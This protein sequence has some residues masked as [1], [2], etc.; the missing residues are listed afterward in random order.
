MVSRCPRV[1]SELNRWPSQCT[2]VLSLLPTYSVAASQAC[3][4]HLSLSQIPICLQD[5]LTVRYA[6]RAR[7]RQ[8]S[9]HGQMHAVSKHR[10]PLLCSDAEGRLRLFQIGP[11]CGRYKLFNLSKA[12][13][14]GLSQTDVQQMATSV[15][16]AAL[17]ILPY[18]HKDKDRSEADS[19]LEKERSV[20]M[21]SILGFSVDT[22]RNARSETRYAVRL[23]RTG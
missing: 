8:M 7:T 20:R 11:M 13:N 9:S 3:H 16:L 15:L 10:H 22:K 1:C 2:H 21:A 18:E 6:S 12:Y 14:K 23:H 5:V 4:S 19:E 17:S